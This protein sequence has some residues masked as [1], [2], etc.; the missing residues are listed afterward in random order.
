MKV[1]VVLR[2]LVLLAIG[3]LLSGCA[4]GRMGKNELYS[5][6]QDFKNM[7]NAKGY[8]SV[9]IPEHELLFRSEVVD[10]GVAHNIIFRN[11]EKDDKP[12]KE[13]VGGLD[14]MRG[15]QPLLWVIDVK[16]RDWNRQAYINSRSSEHQ[17]APDAQLVFGTGMPR[18]NWKHIRPINQYPEVKIEWVEFGS[19]RHKELMAELAGIIESISRLK[20]P[21]L[22]ERILERIGSV[23]TEDAA[24]ASAGPMGL[25]SIAGGRVLGILMEMV[26][27][28]DLSQPGYDTAPDTRFKSVLRDL[29]SE[30]QAPANPQADEAYLRRLQQYDDDQAVW[31]KKYGKHLKGGQASE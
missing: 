8:Y 13:S 6:P 17:Y 27:S 21:G 25:A 4:T 10:G 3:T 18:F 15:S 12:G 29:K 23:S 19:E 1:K 11:D 16:G 22:G 14:I 28:A 26:G 5:L 30:R 2:I 20:F 9:L 31:K 7:G 24:A